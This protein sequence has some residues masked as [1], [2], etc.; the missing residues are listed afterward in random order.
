MSAVETPSSIEEAQAPVQ[1]T[2]EVLYRDEHLI[3]VNKPSGLL[4]HRS[5]IDRHETRFAL[6]IVRDQIG[7]YVYPVHRLDKP[8]SGIL[9]LALSPEVA[10]LMGEKFQAQDDVRKSYLAVVR[11]IPPEQ[12]VID[13]ALKE[14]LDKIAD[15]KAKQDKPPQEAIT[16]YR[17][18]QT[19]ELPVQID[20]YPASRYSLV[21]AHPI[22]GRKHQIRRH[23][24]HI[25]H[26]IIGDAK[27]GKGNHNRYFA[28]NLDA[29]RLLLHCKEMIFCHPVTGERLV[30]CAGV[31]DVFGS[32]LERFGWNDSAVCAG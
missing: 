20:R 26:P 32:L 3:A 16:E 11:G 14:K 18:L 4:V 29:D 8:T 22:T 9:L 28:E 23:M 17:R 19:V 13:Y 25:A 21:E 24:K 30:I 12:G 31:D 6:Q 7:Q 15:K 5:M 27:H 10:R 1:E 2:L